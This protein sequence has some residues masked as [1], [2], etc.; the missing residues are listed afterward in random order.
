[1][2]RKHTNTNSKVVIVYLQETT[3]GERIYD[4]CVFTGN[5]VLRMLLRGSA[6]LSAAP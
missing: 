4:S 6:M 1:M 2:T 5:R 3:Q